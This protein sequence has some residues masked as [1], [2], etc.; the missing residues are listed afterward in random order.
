MLKRSFNVR[1]DSEYG[2]KTSNVRRDSEDVPKTSSNVRR[3]SEDVPKTSF[4]VR[5][6]SE[7]VPKTSSNCVGIQ[8]TCRTR[9]QPCMASRRRAEHV[10]NRA[11]RAVDVPNT[12]AVQTSGLGDSKDGTMPLFQDPVK[13]E[14]VHSNIKRFPPYGY[15]YPRYGAGSLLGVRGGRGFMMYTPI[16]PIG[17]VQGFGFGI[18]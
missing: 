4:N 11:W 1:R 2:P 15:G 12:S 14:L 13:Q 7:D 16:G 17:Y 3:D 10:G 18:G 6:D 5:R 8:K 9:R